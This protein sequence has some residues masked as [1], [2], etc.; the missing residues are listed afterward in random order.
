[1]TNSQNCHRPS[2][3]LALAALEQAALIARAERGLIVV[4]D[5]RGLE[6]AACECYRRIV[7]ELGRVFD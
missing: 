3:S 4:L 1:M 5:R 7:A 6:A 2:V